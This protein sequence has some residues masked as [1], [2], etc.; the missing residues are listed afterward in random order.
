MLT[1]CLP[2]LVLASTLAEI[3][4]HKVR[5][6][7]ITELLTGRNRRRASTSERRRALLDSC[8]GGE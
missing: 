2:G 1:P 6:L 7:D 5:L 4:E 8:V 3:A